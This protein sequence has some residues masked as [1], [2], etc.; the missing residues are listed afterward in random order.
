MK[1]AKVKR[2]EQVRK[3]YMKRGG[4]RVWWRR[5]EELLETTREGRR[6]KGRGR[7]TGVNIQTKHVESTFGAVYQGTQALAGPQNCAEGQ[8]TRPCK[9]SVFKRGRLI[10]RP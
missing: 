8:Q 9:F 3:N 6:E 2:E 4:K 10:P 7:S 5:E 1:E